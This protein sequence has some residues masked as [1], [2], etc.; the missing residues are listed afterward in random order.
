MANAG[1][2]F[3]DHIASLLA[4]RYDHVRTEIQLTGKKADVR[5][6]VQIGPRR[7]IPVAAEC[8]KWNRALTRDDVRDIIRNYDAAIQKREIEEVW[9]VCDRTPAA[10]ARDYV[11]AYRHCQI[12]TA[13]ECEQS[14][15]DFEPLVTF[16]AEDFAGDRVAKYYIPPMFDQS[17]G[18]RD[19]HSYVVPLLDGNQPAPL[20]I[21]AGYGMGKTTYARY[22]ASLLAK[23]CREDYGA[24]I[25]ILLSL[26]EFTTAVNLESLIVSTLTNH[27]GVR[28]LSTIAFRLLNQRHRFV[29]IFDGFDEMKFAMA[30]NEFNFIAAQMRQA[31]AV[32]PRLILLGRPSSISSDEEEERLT[33]S[34]LVVDELS[35]RA[36]DGPNFASLRLSSLTQPEYLDLI[37]N[38]LQHAPEERSKKR[39]IAQTMKSIESMNLGDILQRPVQAKMLAEVVAEPDFDLTKISRF[40]LYSMFIRKVLRREEEKSARRH[41]GTSQRM[42]FMRLLAWWLWTEKKS[43][44]FTANEIPT[45]LIQKFEMPDIPLEGLRRELLVGSVVEEKNVGHFLAEKDAGVFYFPH[46]SFTEFL[47]A[48]YTMSTDFNSIDVKKVPDALYGEVPSFL[49][50]HPSKN[51]ILSLYKRMKAAQIAMSSDCLNVLLNDF[52]VRMAI[53]LFKMDRADAWDVCLHYLFIRAGGWTPVSIRQWLFDCLVSGRP[54][55]ELAAIYCSMY[56]HFLATMAAD[57]SVASMVLHIFRKIGFDIL[58][59]ARERGQSVVRTSEVNHLAT[60][61]SNSIS[62]GRDRSVV[63]DFN[64]F[65]TAALPYIGTSCAVPDVI[66]RMASA[67]RIPENN[68]LAAAADAAERGL[69]NELL[70]KE[71]KFKLTATI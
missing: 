26:G 39:S 23:K 8:K 70:A 34:K 55:N 6:D 45:E 52:N 68:L 49:T 25:P 12:M 9:I 15:V 10:G 50:E 40:S 13:T 54:T 33:S 48:D 5:F 27:Y 71:A 14:I 57:R 20:A 17:D 67:Y 46:T 31:A 58:I 38:F 53:E 2:D 28:N 29:L 22:L 1:D 4:T 35:A 3:R 21:W 19:L 56:E 42:H 64:E 16:L 7:C 61:V 69:I 59:A 11:S 63:F 51:A 36:D 41:L 24:R 47:V 44:T 43:R 62:I 30:P 18:R 37:R 32:N 66:D 65:T 60:I